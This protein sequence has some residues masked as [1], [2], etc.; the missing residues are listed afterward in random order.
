[1]VY[2]SSLTGI[3]SELCWQ[4]CTRV[5][6]SSWYKTDQ[7]IIKIHGT[8]WTE[9]SKISAK[10]EKL[11]EMLVWLTLKAPPIFCSRRQFKILPLF[12]KK[13]I[14]HYIS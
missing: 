8:S 10:L 1:M 6:R 12:P 11:S 5:P 4:L 7:M 3:Q 14:R 9:E 13:P 2:I